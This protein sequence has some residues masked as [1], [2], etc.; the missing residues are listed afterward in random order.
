MSALLRHTER[1]CGMVSTDREVAEKS[2][3]SRSLHDAMEGRAK[4]WRVHKLQKQRIK[5]LGALLDLKMQTPISPIAST[6]SEPA[7]LMPTNTSVAENDIPSA[8]YGHK[9]TEDQTRT[10]QVVRIPALSRFDVDTAFERFELPAEGTV[11]FPSCWD[12]VNLDSA[13]HKSHMAYPIQNY[14]SGDCPA[15]HPV[16]L[17]SL[18]YEM[19]VSVD[20]FPYTGAGTWVLANGDTTA[21]TSRTAGM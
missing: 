2:A 3:R 6:K 19:L 20:Q 18:F 16:H 1:S 17:V 4:A 21:A 13:D 15:S 11:F 10:M 5:E 14:N 7:T 9:H 8:M 12:G